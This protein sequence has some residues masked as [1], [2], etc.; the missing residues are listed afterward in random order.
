LI[1]DLFQHHHKPFERPVNLLKAVLKNHG[2]P[3][4]A[5][6]PE[7]NAVVPN[8]IKYKSLSVLCAESQLLFQ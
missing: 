1:I 4:A 2:M 3:A 8:M 5:L 6:R 7:G